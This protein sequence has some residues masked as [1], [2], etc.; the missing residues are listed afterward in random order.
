MRASG[1]PDEKSKPVASRRDGGDA[2]RL[3]VIQRVRFARV[4]GRVPRARV[5]EERATVVR[6][7]DDEP[8][9]S[10]DVDGGDDGRE[11]A[12]DGASC[13][14]ADVGASKRPIFRAVHDGRV[15]V[16]RDA[17]DEVFV[18]RRVG[19]R[20][21]G[22]GRDDDGARAR[23]SS[24]VA[25]PVRVEAFGAT[26]DDGP[27]AGAGDGRARRPIARGDGDR[28]GRKGVYG[29]RGSPDVNGG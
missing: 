19:V 27:V 11:R 21:E 22:F 4:H 15:A 1:R 10:R 12:D 18:P 16:A 24:P 29:G 23:A 25:D 14:G 3:G 8:R 6:A 13:A 17:R 28:C 7:D 9:V 5:E 26:R 2:T 20:A